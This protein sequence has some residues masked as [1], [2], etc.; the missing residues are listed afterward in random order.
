MKKKILFISHPQKNCGVHEFGR[1]ISDALQ[2]S[3]QFN[4]VYIECS[5][6]ADLQDAIDMHSPVAV[7][8]NYHFSTLPWLTQKIIHTKHKPL[9]RHI[10]I[11]QIGIMHEV[12]QEKADTATSA[13]F[14]YYIAPDPTLLLKNPI[15][16]KTGRLIPEYNN[17]FTI[18]DKPVIGS[19]GFATPNK[20]FEEIV[21]A[22]QNEFDIAAIRFNIPAADFGDRDGSNAAKLEKKCNQLIKKPGVTLIVT[23]DFLEQKEI[24]DFL[25]QNSINVFL[26]QDKINR[27]LSSTPDYALAVNRPLA[28]SDSI[29]FRHLHTVSPTIVYGQSTLKQIIKNGIDPLKE[30]QTDWNHITLVWEYERIIKAILKK[31]EQKK[32][33]KQKNTWSTVKT[34]IRNFLGLQQNKFTWLRNTEAATDDIL[35]VDPSQKYIPVHLPAPNVFNR[36]LDNN[37]R[38]LYKPAI[39]KLEELVPLTMAKK[40]SE[41]NVQQAFVFDTVYRLSAN[42]KNSKILCVGSYED[43]AAMSLKRLGFEVE[44]IDPVLNYY[45]Q[46]FFSKPTTIKNSYDIIFST[47]VIE[48]DPDDESFIK[49]IEGLLAPQGIAILT[50]DYK[51]GWQPG[52]PKPDVDAR[53]YTKYDLTTRLLSYIPECKLIDKPHWECKNPDFNYLGKYQYTFATFVI[54]KTKL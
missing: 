28:V 49:C 37:A 40:I 4:F 12:T 38:L 17:P 3:Q 51:D 48:H 25:A 46:E 44:E 50:C 15:V 21:E 11:P 24:L 45:L 32:Y 7:I 39:K 6:M 43:T 22:V 19:F 34:Q 26:Y 42:Y 54:Q 14:N 27:G 35:T 41:A 52:E 30:I 47:S 20:G 9:N 2:S 23:H 13:L 31:E 10:S 5:S 33:N 36:I 1:A 53:F 18:P 16:F 29:M 8:Y